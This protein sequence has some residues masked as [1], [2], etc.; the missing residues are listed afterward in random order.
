MSFTSSN[1]Y[2]MLVLF[3]NNSVLTTI[4][5]TFFATHYD[6]NI[7]QSPVCAALGL[8]GQK[9]YLVLNI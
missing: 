2:F 7:V 5:N 9:M 1:K 4:N 6:G 8:N 3:Y